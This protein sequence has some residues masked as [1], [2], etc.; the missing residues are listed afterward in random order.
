MRHETVVSPFMLLYISME[1]ETRYINYGNQQVN[2]EDFL[3]N[4]ADQVQGY[5]AS[6]PWSTKRKEKFL[7]AYQDIMS[8]GVVG[9]N[10]SSGQW[11]IDINGNDLNLENKP[12]KEMY[13]EAAYFIQ[14]Q[15]AALAQ[16]KK[17]EKPTENLTKFDN[18]YLNNNLLE[19]ITNNRF[20]GQQGDISSLWNSFDTQES[21]IKNRKQKL[22]ED[23]TNW[24]NNLDSSKYSFEGTPFA[25]YNDFNQRRLNAIQALQNSGD[26]LDEN[27]REALLKLGLNPDQFFTITSKE[28]SSNDKTPQKNINYNTPSQQNVYIAS[29]YNLKGALKGK[30]VS[31]LANKYHSNPQELLASLQG[32][33]KRGWTNLNNDEREEI[34]GTIKYGGQTISDNEHNILKNMSSGR[35]RGS[36]NK[37]RF[38]KYEGLEG[39]IYDTKTGQLI[40]I[41]NKIDADLGKSSFNFM[42]G[43]SREEINN[44]PRGNGVKLT[45]ADKVDLTALAADLASILYPGMAGGAVLGGAAAALRATTRDWS[46]DFWGNLGGTAVDLGTGVVGGLP[47]FGDAILASKFLRGLGNVLK[48]AAVYSAFKSSPEAFEAIRKIDFNHPIDSAK[49]LTPQDYHAIYNVLTGILAGKSHVKT[50]LA[51][52]QVLKKKGVAVEDKKLQK[53]GIRRTQIK[54]NESVPTVKVKDKNGVE[55]DLVIKPETKTTLEKQLKGK[56]REQKN[57]IIKENK[58]IKDAA[59]KAGIDISKSEIAADKSILNWPVVR[60]YAGTNKGI[61]GTTSGKPISREN[62]QFEKYLSERGWWDKFKYGTNRD[63]KRISDNFEKQGIYKPSQTS[64]NKPESQNN[65]PQVQQSTSSYIPEDVDNRTLSLLNNMK[66]PKRKMSRE[67]RI[68]TPKNSTTNGQLIDGSTFQVHYGGKSGEMTVNYKGKDLKLKGNLHSQ[69]K[70]LGQWIER[71]NRSI[72]NISKV[73]MKSSDPKWEKYVKS[74]KDLKRKGF[75]FKEGGQIYD[76]NTTISEFLKT[77]K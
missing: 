36:K 48:G 43:K 67:T 18:Q 44:T 57:N 59:K 35:W 70:R 16:D 50:N 46:N 56:T 62:D 29:R 39:L 14:Q 31:Y 11:G 65:T 34:I 9:A 77:K 13:Y 2:Y 3:N 52:R 33:I 27:S 66:G 68:P 17:E 71:Q 40:H 58:D 28:T 12:N 24:G 30:D 25:D 5:V 8:K 26:T 1:K 69:K 54:E 4:A 51:E 64:N 41:Q 53:F 49:K 60:N 19:Y 15:M 63:L 7:E 32:Y 74:I 38:K 23:L 45:T 42:A 55:H 20:G 76:V 75:L 73:K 72:S 37:A 10:N 22:I 6:M 47:F 21:G 61:F